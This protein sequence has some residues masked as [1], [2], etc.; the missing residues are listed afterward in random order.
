MNSKKDIEKAVKRLVVDNG[1][2]KARALSF[3]HS[4]YRLT[5]YFLVQK[6]QKAISMF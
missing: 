3:L 5:L 4:Y 2:D 1:W 6:T